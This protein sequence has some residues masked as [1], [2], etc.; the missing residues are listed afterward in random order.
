MHAA[1]HAMIRFL[2][3]ACAGFAI[4]ASGFIGWYLQPLISADL[5]YERLKAFSRPVDSNSKRNKT[6]RSWRKD[7]GANT[8]S[9]LCPSPELLENYRHIDW[10]ALAA[11]N[12]SVIGWIYVPNTPIDYPIVQAPTDDPE[13]Y[14]RTT[15]EGSVSHPNNQGTIYL[16]PDNAAGGLFSSA[17]IIYGHYQLNG[18][19]LSSFSKNDSVDELAKH[20]R[21]FLYTPTTMFHVELFAGNIVDAS[22]EKIRTLFVDQLD[23]SAWINEKLDESEAVLYRP[24]PINQLFTFVT[25]SYSQ[26][27]DQRTL[28]YGRLLESAPVETIEYYSATEASSA[29]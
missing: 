24:P 6:D 3:S 12:S 25:C 5:E 28:T 22:K 11:I 2:I 23:L 26:W 14:L 1:H 15:F 29:D 10:E 18:S 17:P 19:M 7:E 4:M 27:K 13:K 21:V 20:N 16:D 9:D 8:D